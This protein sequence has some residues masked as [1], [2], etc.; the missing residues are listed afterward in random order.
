MRLVEKMAKTAMEVL[1][2]STQYFR[3]NT[4]QDEDMARQIVFII[5]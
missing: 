5:D 1:S 2:T 4:E 3:E